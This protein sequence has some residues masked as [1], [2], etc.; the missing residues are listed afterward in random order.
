MF[1]ACVDDRSHLSDPRHPVSGQGQSDR[2]HISNDCVCTAVCAIQ[3]SSSSRLP[4]IL[5]PSVTPLI[6]SQYKQPSILR[7]PSIYQTMTLWLNEW[8]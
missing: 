7:P 4:S 2:T 8:I 3:D 1:A 5:R 6:Y